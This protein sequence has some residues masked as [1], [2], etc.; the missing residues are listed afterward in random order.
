MQTYHHTLSLI[1]DVCIPSHPFIWLVVST[2][3]KNISQNGIISPNRV[4]NK[5]YLSCHHL[6]MFY[7]HL[8]IKNISFSRTEKNT[9]TETHGVF[10]GFAAS[11]WNCRPRRLGVRP[12]KVIQTPGTSPVKVTGSK[13]PLTRRNRSGQV[14]GEWFVGR[15]YKKISQKYLTGMGLFTYIIGD[16]PILGWFT[17]VRV[18]H[19]C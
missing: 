6:V 15:G 2:H 16:L 8:W 17:Y 5:K 10:G 19:L 11:A 1:Q 18:I 9:P 7:L 3:L 13:T 12:S 14:N 4:E